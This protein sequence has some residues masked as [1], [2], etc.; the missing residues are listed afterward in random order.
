MDVE[1]RSLAPEGGG[2]IELMVQFLD[3]LSHRLRTNRDFELA[4]G[5]LAL[6]L[7]VCFCYIGL[8]H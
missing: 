7:K 3:C 2:S 6:F 1:L 4:Q 8:Y 5:Y